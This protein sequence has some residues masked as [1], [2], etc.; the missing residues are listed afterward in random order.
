MKHE[1]LQHSANRVSKSASVPL[2]LQGSC[3]RNPQPV[4]QM[5]AVSTLVA[6]GVQVGERHH[7]TFDAGQKQKNLAFLSPRLQDGFV[8]PFSAK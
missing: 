1:F 3:G 2:G 6:D 8:K 4:G 5:I 7:K